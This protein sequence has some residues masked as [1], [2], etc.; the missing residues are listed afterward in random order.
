MPTKKALNLERF[1]KNRINKGINPL[2][3][4]TPVYPAERPQAQLY[5]SYYNKYFTKMSELAKKGIGY[6]KGKTAALLKELFSLS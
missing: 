3:I 4:M 6:R 1:E 2:A 5:L